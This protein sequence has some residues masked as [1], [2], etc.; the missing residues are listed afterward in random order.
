MK[1]VED[2]MLISFLK[3]I[4][5]S[6][7]SLKCLVFDVYG[8]YKVIHKLSTRLW[9]FRFFVHWVHEEWDI[10]H[11]GTY[12]VGTF[13]TFVWTFGTLVGTFGTSVGTF[14]TLM[15]TFGTLVGTFGTLVGTFGKLMETFG[16]LVG[17]FGFGTLVGTFGTLFLLRIWTKQYCISLI[18]I[19]FIKEFQI[20]E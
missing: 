3:K 17:T 19:T 13:V 4:Q 10:T 14:G 2:R 8:C 5:S 6:W 20:K 11:H 1:E 9:F 15:G 12:L 7:S 16:T 18:C